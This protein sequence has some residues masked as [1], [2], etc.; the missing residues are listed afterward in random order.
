M[1]TTNLRLSN[2]IAR[3]E[4]AGLNPVLGAPFAVTANNIV[5]NLRCE[6]DA[7]RVIYCLAVE[8]PDG[9]YELY[10]QQASPMIAMDVE[11][12][13]ATMRDYGCLTLANRA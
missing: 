4:D 8:L 11:F 5:R 9:F 1:N 7:G 2:L 6:S 10:V 3:L 12:I 13:E